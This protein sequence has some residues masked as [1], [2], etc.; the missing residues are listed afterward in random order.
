[1]AVEKVAPPSFETAEH[2]AYQQIRGE[3]LSGEL[4]GGASLNQDE[5]A[6][7]LNVSRTPIR[8]AFLRLGSEGLITN[9]PHH[10]S[11]VTSLSAHDIFEL[12]EIRSLLEGYAVSLAVSKLDARSRNTLKTRAAALEKSETSSKHWLDLHNEFHNFLCSLADRPRLVE[13]VSSLRQRVIPYLRLYL[14]ANKG[15]EIRGHEHQTILSV[16]ESGDPVAA[17]QAMRAHVMS[18]ARGVVEFVSNQEQAAATGKSGGS[19]GFDMNQL[20]KPSVPKPDSQAGTS[21]TQSPERRRN[22]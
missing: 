7:R 10:G 9:R 8:Q 3:I 15:T 16:I 5:I 11:V 19:A 20:M 13:Q 18:A 4:P 12:F 17:E 2:Y 22:R 21:R 14:S 6:K 1:M